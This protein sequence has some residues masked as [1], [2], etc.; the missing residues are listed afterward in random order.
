LA[1]KFLSVTAL[2]GHFAIQRCIIL[3]ENQYIR[4]V[5]FF[6][7]LR[8][9]L[10]TTSQLSVLAKVTHNIEEMTVSIFYFASVKRSF[11][12]KNG[13]RA[14]VGEGPFWPWDGL[15]CRRD[16]LLPRGYG[17]W[18]EVHAQQLQCCV[19]VSCDASD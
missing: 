7:R 11:G 6:P 19:S 17:D 10:L 9:T 12:M 1:L 14:L 8:I 3:D 15:S 18:R 2:E 5:L 4:T 13:T 16:L